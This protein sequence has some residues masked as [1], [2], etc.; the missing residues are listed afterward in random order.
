MA[1]ASEPPEDLPVRRRCTEFV[2]VPRS[3]ELQAAEDALSL[4][5]VAA[6]GGTRPAV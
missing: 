3:T 2:I 4:T 1:W 6:V 5:L